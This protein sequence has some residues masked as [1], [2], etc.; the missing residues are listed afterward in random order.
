MHG[1]NLNKPLEQ[2]TN[3]REL[4]TALLHLKNLSAE[5]NAEEIENSKQNTLYARGYAPVVKKQSIT[6]SRQAPKKTLYKDIIKTKVSNLSALLGR[7]IPTIQIEAYQPDMPAYLGEVDSV[8][9]EAEYAS[10]VPA[11]L[12]QLVIEGEWKERHENAIQKKIVDVSLIDG[13]AFRCFSVKPD[14]YRGNKIYSELIQ[15]DRILLDPATTKLETLE[16]CRWLILL[17]QMTAAEIEQRWGIKEKEY[18]GSSHSN[19]HYSE[20]SGAV[21]VFSEY[22]DKGNARSGMEMKRYP[23]F[24]LFWQPGQPDI[25]RFQDGD[26]GQRDLRGRMY[27]VIND[28]K[29]AV[30]GFAQD[31]MGMYPV[32]AYSHDPIPYTFSGHSIVSNLKGT[33]DFVTLLYNLIAQN[34]MLRGGYTFMAEPGAVKQQNFKL[35]ANGTM[36]PVAVGALRE[37]KIQEMS[38]GDIGTSIVNFMNDEVAYARELTGDASG[39]LAGHVSSSVKSGK[40]AQTILETSNTQIGQYISMLDIGHKQAAYIEALMTQANVDML[41]PL[42]AK[43]YRTRDLLDIDAAVRELDFTVEVLSK[44]NLPAT[45]ISAELNW[46]AIQYNLGVIHI[47]DYLKNTE[48]LDMFCLLYT[49]PSPRD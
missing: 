44:S 11:D 35:G 25:L 20:T 32:V 33:Q 24:A 36:I 8:I 31:L 15:R 2:I 27:I 12:L 45:S 43:R 30:N 3:E 37:K 38:P 40:H 23:V 10:L 26:Q 39:T 18:H 21:R 6:N 49:S 42:Y 14:R 4:L 1:D 17:N 46:W 22:D 41:N 48:Q 34:A 7:A 47:Y 16:D 29:I 28:T 19:R 5:A 9:R 13:V